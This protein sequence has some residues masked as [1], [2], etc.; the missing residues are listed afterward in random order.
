MF[1]YQRQYCRS[2]LLDLKKKLTSSDPQYCE[3]DLTRDPVLSDPDFEEYLDL[4]QAMYAQRDPQRENGGL[5][6]PGRY[7]SQTTG[8]YA[9]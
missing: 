6:V 1:H 5:Y 4:V 9:H 7:Y 8:D 2:I 3:L